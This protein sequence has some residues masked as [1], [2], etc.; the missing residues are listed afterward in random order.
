MKSFNEDEISARVVYSSFLRLCKIN[1]NIHSMLGSEG[2]SVLCFPER[3]A[4]NSRE[5]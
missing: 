5:N 3:S 2:K 4:Q 1:D